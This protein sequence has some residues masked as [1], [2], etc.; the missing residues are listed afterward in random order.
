[1]LGELL[2]IDEALVEGSPA[3]VKTDA[4]EANVYVPP[5][6]QAEIQ[7]WL[8]WRALDPRAWLFPAA[9]GGPWSAQNYL[10]RVL[11]PAAVRAGVGVFAR[12][13]EK[14]DPVQS[15]H[16]NFQVLRRTCATLFGAKAKDPRDTQAQLRHADPTV[17]LRHYQK[18]IPA[19]VRA[20]A[21]ALEEELIGSSA[22]R[23]EQVLNRSAFDDGLEV[24]EIYGATRRDRTGDLLITKPPVS[25]LWSTFWSLF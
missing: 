15:T 24:F 6:L 9:M 23:T 14:G 10:N 5:D 20:A 18:S 3:P 11:K 7:A 21:V 17:T 13:S 19:S 1:M 22:D 2:R 8:E 4:S 12:K 25:S 16:V